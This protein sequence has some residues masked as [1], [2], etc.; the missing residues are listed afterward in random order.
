MVRLGVGQVNESVEL[1][2]V[3]KSQLAKNPHYAQIP[4][5]ECYGIVDGNGAN[6]K[7][8]IDE[9][10]TCTL[11]AGSKL[12]QNVAPSIPQSIANSRDELQRMSKLVL[13]PD[14]TLELTED[15]DVS[16]TS[17]AASA[18]DWRSASGPSSWQRS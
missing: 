13:Q 18:V 10:G 17:Y 16:S 5:N 9:T 2:S 1:G 14:G 11:L 8:R 7:M 4:L 12:R 15:L 6:A 3:P